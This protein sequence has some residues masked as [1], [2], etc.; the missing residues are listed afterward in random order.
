[1]SSYGKEVFNLH[2]ESSRVLHQFK[3]QMNLYGPNNQH[4][5]MFGRHLRLKGKLKV[6]LLTVLVAG[7]AEW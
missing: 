2:T 6:T 7:C 1:M 5:H 3:L 4:P